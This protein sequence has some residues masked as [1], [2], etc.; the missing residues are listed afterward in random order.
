VEN[1][2]TEVIEDAVST[3]GGIDNITSDS[4]DNVSIV[5]IEFE[6][7]TDLDFAQMDVKDKVD[8]ILSRLPEDA[9]PPVVS[10]VDLGATPLME[11][12]VTG[13]RP[14]R[15]IY[16]LTDGRIKDALSRIAGVASVDMSGGEEREIQVNLS[17]EE[18]KGYGL[19]I[20]DVVQMVNAGNLSAPSG[21]IIQSEEE[22]SVR[23]E[24]KFTDLDELRNLSIFLPT[25]GKVKLGSLGT[26][27]DTSAEK[28][29]KVRYGGREGVALSIVKL[30]D[31]QPIELA[32]NVRKTI[33]ELE[34]A[35]PDDI[36]IKIV[37]DDSG[38]ILD[39]VSDVQTNII[40]GIILTSIF[41]FLFLHSLRMTIIVAIIMPTC[42]ISS[43]L[44]MDA[45]GFTLNIMSTLGLGLSIGTLVINAI[46]ILENITRR[47][48]AGDSPEVAAAEGT[49]EVAVAVIA[50]AMTNIFVFTPIAFMSGIIG[51][52]FVQFAL[53]VVY[54][55]LFSLWMSFTL[56][57][58][59]ASKILKPREEGKP[60]AAFFRLWD[61]GM[62]R[63]ERGYTVIL[64]WS[65]AHL[66]VNVVAAVVL[67]CVAVL[68]M[69]MLGGEFIPQSNQDFITINVEMPPGTALDKTDRMMLEIEDT[70]RSSPDVK[71]VLTTIGKSSGLD[72]GVEFANL[73]VIL[74]KGHKKHIIQVND[75]LRTLLT[76][77]FPGVMLQNIPAG[78][79]PGTG[80]DITI[81]VLGDEPDELAEITGKV[82][83]IMDS[84]PEL[85]GNKSSVRT[86][87]PEITFYPDRNQLDDY[88]VTAAEVAQVL[89]ASL[90]GLVDSTYEEGDEEYDIRI[91]LAREDLSIAEDA[92]RILIRT[93]RGLTPLTALG[94][95][96]FTQGETRITRKNKQNMSTVEANIVE[97]SLTEVV[98]KIRART[99]QIQLPPGYGINFGGTAE[100]QAESMTAIVVALAQA[101]ILTYMLI[102]AILGSY[103]HP[104]TIMLT[105]PLGFVGAILAMFCFGLTINIFSMLAMIMLVGIVVNDAILM[106]DQTGTFRKQGYSAKAALLKACP[107]KLRTI[108]MTNSA[109][110]ISMFP[111]TL[112]SQGAAIMRA[113]L[114]IVEIGA[115]VVQT[116]CTLTVIP[117]LYILLDRF[118]TTKYEVETGAEPGVEEEIEE[119]DMEKPEN[120]EEIAEEEP[121][122]DQTP[123]G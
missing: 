83:A 44:L 40:I 98:K 52:F 91:Q 101:I 74:P 20:T 26:V 39:S 104:F 47:L 67:I 36:D 10:K 106:L 96:A 82:K 16:D 34:T 21:R 56:T 63:L 19:S 64:D 58:M 71:D 97:G 13:D 43:F 77:K 46:V 92:E 2:V 111:Q 31:S 33:A 102:A 30:S 49:S 55:T 89:V 79:G 61:R 32:E 86:G 76:G 70:I 69:R 5:K 1:Q 100:T 65:L 14:L 51:S 37:K 25:G 8:A 118:S 87:K 80:V 53:T 7:G 23:L 68:L 119:P 3:I 109:I 112:G 28:R 4:L 88:G 27:E 78:M 17:R 85:V 103:L 115:V 105:I 62:G 116:T 57:P 9:D 121:E 72:E 35:L 84:M 107:M 22:F 90:T 99:E 45:S 110:A 75:E 48:D 54:A 113:S 42:I 120:E 73:L 59:L 122:T 60:K 66:W 93:R 95:I 50:S 38:I 94:D 29:K 114:S 81:E 12:M 108:I 24:G 18:L 117:V 41:L 6:F 15:E 123:E 11:L